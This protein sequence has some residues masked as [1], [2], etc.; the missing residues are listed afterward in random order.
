[1]ESPEKISAADIDESQKGEGLR[2]AKTSPL[3]VDRCIAAELQQ[4]RLVRM[5]RKRELLQPQSHRVPEAPR[6]GFVLEAGHNIIRVPQDD[7]VAFGFP[8]SPPVGP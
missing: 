5:E 6:V 1:M 7:D 4:P 2:S 8:P 3:A